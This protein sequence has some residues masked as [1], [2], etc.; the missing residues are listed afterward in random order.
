VLDATLAS[1][2]SSPGRLHDLCVAVE[3]VTPGEIRSGGGGLTIRWGCHPSPFGACFIAATPRGVCR[4]AFSEP[5]ELDDHVADLR[6]EWPEATILQDAPETRR[7]LGHVLESLS[8][9]PTAPLSVLVKGTNFQIQVWRALVNI[10]VGRVVSYDRVAAAVG[11]PRGARAVGSAVGANRVAV[12]IPCHRVIRA[13][14]AVGQYHWGS[15]RKRALLAWE[16][17]KPPPASAVS[18][19]R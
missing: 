19:L 10:P 1:G 7:L 8:G 18:E 13:T 2:L 14:G 4:L 16:A 15:D 11:R 6:L 17:V 12:L 3:A 5:V 9:E